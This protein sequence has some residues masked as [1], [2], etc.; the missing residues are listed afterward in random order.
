MPRSNNVFKRASNRLLDFLADLPTGEPLP[1][2]SELARQ[3]DVSRTTIRVAT[4][5]VTESGVLVE[6]DGQFYAG[7]KPAEAD[8]FAATQTIS[9]TELVERCFMERVLTG[10]LKPGHP[11][12]E[13]DLARASGTSLPSVRE[14]LIGFARFGLIKKRPH[15]GWTL[16]GFSRDF[17]NELADM[18]RIIELAAI[19]SLATLAPDAPIFAAVPS[20]IMRHHTLKRTIRTKYLEFPKLDR[21]FHFWLISSLNNR[22]TNE[23]F[24]LVSL[25]FHYHFQWRTEHEMVRHAVAI[26]EHLAI[27]DALATRDFIAARVRLKDHLMTSRLTLIGSIRNDPAMA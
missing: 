1:T 16:H 4:R 6:R 24:D 14:F 20:L 22:F 25:I 19:D 3:L 18:R 17:A 13:T 10:E 7:R 9:R 21:D 2:V 26:D 15:G 27:L 12:S 23:Y 11:F 5:H 8:Y